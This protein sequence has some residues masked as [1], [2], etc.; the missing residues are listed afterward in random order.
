MNKNILIVGAIIVVLLLGVGGFS[1]LSKSKSPV[2]S[3]PE[4]TMDGQNEVGAI[5]SIKDF[6]TQSGSMKCEI[7]DEGKTTTV[8][9]KNGL[10]RV[11][12]VG[13]EAQDN[14]SI[15]FNSKEKKFYAWSTQ[16]KQGVSMSVSDETMDKVDKKTGSTG[17]SYEDV[18]E[19]LEK[20]KDSCKNASVSDSLF[21]VP[22]DVKFQDLS[23]M[24]SSGTKSAPNSQ[25]IEEM[26]K[27]YVPQQ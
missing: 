1:L 18:M 3:N 19:D 2:N 14:S 9:I 22:T 24:M 7:E 11:D 13:A 8:Y 17:D 25:Q 12:S 20:Y 21:T 23:T 16:T 6:L 15:I 26:M 4:G 10:V 27:Q 5:S